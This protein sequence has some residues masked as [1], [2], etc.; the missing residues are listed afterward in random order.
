[1]NVTVSVVPKRTRTPSERVPTRFEVDRVHATDGDRWIGGTGVHRSDRRPP[2]R[3]LPRRRRWP[4]AHDLH[5]RLSSR[6]SCRHRAWLRQP[7]IRTPPGWRRH[8]SR[9]AARRPATSCGAL[10]SDRR[11]CRSSNEH[12]PRRRQRPAPGA[13]PAHSV[14]APESV[15][16]PIPADSRL[17]AGSRRPQW[18]RHRDD[19]TDLRRRQTGPG[20]GRPWLRSRSPRAP[21]DR[22]PSGHRRQRSRRTA[23]QRRASRRAG[24][25][26]W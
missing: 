22:R 26:G 19:V 23:G 14:R 24:R 20:C 18:P 6:G 16:S 25:S 2:G 15:K 17:H 21:V 12:L 11:R 3:K 7:A 4:A 8:R 5:H 13:V 9:S 1:M 10:A